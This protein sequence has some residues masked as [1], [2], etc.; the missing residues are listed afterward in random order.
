MRQEPKRLN[1][2]IPRDEIQY[3]HASQS[4]LLNLSQSKPIKANHLLGCDENQRVTPRNGVV[5]R[6]HVRRTTDHACRYPVVAEGQH[7]GETGERNPR[8]I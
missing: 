4:Y 6:L 2:N 1:T 8:Y 5:L 7:L 3:E